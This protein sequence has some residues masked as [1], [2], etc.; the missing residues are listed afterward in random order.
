MEKGEEMDFE[1]TEEQRLIQ[2]MVRE[3]AENEV[4]PIAAEID[5]NHRWPEETIARMREL[6]ILGLSVP[7]AYGGSG[8][9]TISYSLAIEELSRVCGSHGAI[10]AVH[11]GAINAIRLFGTEEQ[12][13]KFIPEMASGKRIACL[14][15]TEPGAGTDASAQRTRA[16]RDGNRYIINGGKIFITNGPVGGT[17]VVLCMTAPEKGVKGISAFIVN[18]ETHGL[19]IGQIEDKLGIRASVTSEVFFEDMAVPAENLLGGEGQGFKVVMKTLD[20]GRIGM[21]SQAVGIAQGA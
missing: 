21:A 19:K 17:Y 7:E 10:L 2:N 15:M 11:I 8:G 18:R 6:D 4:R 14:C 1:L 9:G 16:V 3:F 13:L 20:I 5:K 12:K